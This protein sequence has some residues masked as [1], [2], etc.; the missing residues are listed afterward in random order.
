V[1]E[2]KT[3]RIAGTEALLRWRHP[4][5]GIVAPME[6]IPMAEETGLIVR[7]GAWVIEEACQQAVA[8]Q[9]TFR[10]DPP[11]SMSVN[12]SPRQLQQPE[13][14]DVV[15]DALQSSGLR[16]ETLILEITETAMM[17]DTEMAI[18]RLE[19][20]KAL[21]VKLAVDDFGTG[22]SSLNYLRRFPVDVL[23]VDKSFIDEVNENGEQSALTA[24]II[25]LAS[26]LQLRPVAEGIERKEQLDRLLE[27]QCAWGQGFLFFEP[28]TRQELEGVLRESTSAPSHRP[29]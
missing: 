16:P 18:F 10:R 29:R 24:A 21:G 6:F 8:L 9:S 23:K 22:Y 27:L 5:R 3:G 7:I 1:V 26:T 11:L 19:Q 14:V 4:E 13:L 17:Q 15:R 25:E 20:L 2:L 28:L 12:L